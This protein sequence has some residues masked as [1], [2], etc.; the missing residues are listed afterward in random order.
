MQQAVRRNAEESRCGGRDLCRDASARR[1]CA[2]GLA[3]V[4]RE[5][6]AA[7]VSGE[8]A[9]DVAAQEGRLGLIPSEG[10]EDAGGRIDRKPAKC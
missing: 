6:P 1:M 5:E 8:A 10:R 3:D 2:H 4:G 9:C 7:I